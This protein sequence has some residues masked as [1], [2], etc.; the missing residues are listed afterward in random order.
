MIGSRGDGL[1]HP[2]VSATSSVSDP[3]RYTSRIAFA[4]GE[5]LFHP[6]CQLRI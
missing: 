5:L 3:I 6:T 4:T 1:S 2:R